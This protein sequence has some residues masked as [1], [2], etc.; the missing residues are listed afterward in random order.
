MYT[1]AIFLD[2]NARPHRARLVQSYLESE[3]IPQMLRP[4]RSPDLNTIEHAW[5]MLG[6]QIAGRNVPPGTLHELQQVLLQ[7]WALLPQQAINNTIA[8]MP[9]CCRTCISAR[10]YKTRYYMWFPL[11]ILPSNLGYRAD[12]FLFVFDLLFDMCLVM[13]HL[14]RVQLSRIFIK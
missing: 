6:R 10:G 11:H 5:D 13:P 8:S 2:Y 4:A 12:V 1:D 7:E 14:H 9:R 3:S